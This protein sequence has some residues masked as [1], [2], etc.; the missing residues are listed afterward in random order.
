ME[1]N[2]KFRKGPKNTY[3]FCIYNIVIFINLEKNMLFPY[4]VLYNW[5]NIKQ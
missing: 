5:M 4:L 1:Q 3:D 2:E